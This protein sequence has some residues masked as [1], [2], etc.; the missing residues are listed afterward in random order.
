MAVLQTGTVWFWRRNS[1]SIFLMFTVLMN[2]EKYT[3]FP[4]LN[5]QAVVRGPQE[6]CLKIVGW[7]GPPHI[8][9]SKAA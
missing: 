7:Q 3:F 4:Q 5:K 2:S 6:H 1:N 8:N 9:N